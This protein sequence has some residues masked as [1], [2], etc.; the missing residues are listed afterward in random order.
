MTAAKRPL[1]VPFTPAWRLALALREFRLRR[2]SEPVRRLVY[3]VISIGNL[4]TG[5]AGK[6]PFAIALVKALN[7]GGFAV[8]VL[9]RGY[10]RKSG[11]AARVRPAG[12]AEEFGDEPLVIAREA[13]VPVYVAGERYEA[14]LLAEADILS[15]SMLPAPLPEAGDNGSEGEGSAAGRSA[16]VA[17]RPPVHI[18]DDGF[19]HRQLHRD[20]DI[21]LLNREDWHDRLLP[22]GNLREPLQAVRRAHVVAI[23]DDDDELERELR[24][25]GWTG[26]VWRL[27]RR[28]EVPQADG[29]VVA[30]C[31]IAR[32]E[33][34]FAG[35][36]AAGLRL[37]G[38]IA[39]RDHHR[40]TLSDLEKLRAVAARAGAISLVTTRKD[41]VR[42][43]GPNNLSQTATA[44]WGSWSP[45][46]ASPPQ[47]RRPVAGDPGKNVAKMGHGGLGGE[48]QL[49]TAGLRIEIQDEGP[50]LDWLT[51]R[52]SD[53]SARLSM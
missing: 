42:L 4:S 11:T 29:P 32:P 25:W 35:L 8:D 37:A 48:I 12:T 23:P 31:G 39:F 40:Y 51:R 5:G 47:R 9:S 45:T 43:R 19:Q 36:E 3:P 27:H 20:V 30:F 18:L 14:G 22:A 17:Y 1:L 28:M 53:T 38:R 44:G 33:Q 15:P 21:L 16:P 46:F 41:E 24:S 52:L 50:A 13:G 10:G 34:F 6:T 49:V 26:P 7:A 2:G